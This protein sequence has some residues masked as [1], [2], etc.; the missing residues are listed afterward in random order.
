MTDQQVSRR[1]NLR[2]ALAGAIC[3]I[4]LSP[5]AAGLMAAVYRF[6]M[7]FAGYEGGW[8]SAPRAAVAALFYL[9]VGGV[10]V[11]GLV[12]GGAG[13]LARRLATGRR[14]PR[15]LWVSVVFLAAL[16]PAALLSVLD[17]IIGP[18]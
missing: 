13:T 7:P 10:F 2:A 9:L 14:H 12:G 1:G 18:W 17:K 15:L 4:A 11:V 8:G 6:P 3:A 16:A 5:V